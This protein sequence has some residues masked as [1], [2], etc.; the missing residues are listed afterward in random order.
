LQAQGKVIATHLPLH[1]FE[2]YVAGALQVD[3]RRAD[4][5]FKGQVQF[6]DTPAGPQ[7]GVQGDAALDDVRVRMAPVQRAGEGG[8]ADA[9]TVQRR[10]EE[11][12]NWKSLGLRGVD[13][14]LAPGKPVA[15]DVRETALSDF[16]A[17]IIL[18]ANGRINLQDMVRSADASA[19]Q[20]PAPVA[21]GPV[22]AAAAGAAMAP[23][24]Q[25]G[26]VSLTGGRVHFTDYFIQP[27][28]SADLSELTGRIS[29]FSSVPPSAGAA[30]AMAD[31]ELRGR[32]EGTASIEI[33]GK[34]NPLAQPLALDI[35]G[36]MRE[37]ELP[38][39]S[40]YTIKYAGHGI[41]RG[42]L[43]MD[44]NYRV[45]P[46]GQLTA[47][48]KLVLNQLTFGEP[49]DG[50][51]ASL[52]VRL[53]VALL[54]DRNG[55]IDVDLPI[56]GSLNDPEFR[57]GSVILKIIGNLILK[58]VTAPFSLLAGAL[59]GGDELGSVAFAAGS[60]VLDE[61]A[62]QG[63]DKVV[64]ALTDRP[65]LKMTV[66]GMANLE[67]ERD[68]WKRGQLQ[69]NLLAQK[70]RAAL[71]AGQAADEG[72][73]I[74]ADEYPALLKEV[75][76]RSDIAKPRNLVGLAKDLPA[77]EMEALLLASIP[78]S[79]ASMRELALARG[80]AV[81]DYLASRQLPADRL[82]LGAAR[83]VPS[84]A[85]WQPHAELTLGTR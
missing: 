5:S 23:I 46:D 27:N 75:Y 47:S 50:A 58:A 41:E 10:G 54:A 76:R 56:S 11:L 31:L 62:R 71:R 29:A 42:K 2:P 3:I 38:P 43:S 16:F 81:R 1:V 32:A 33:T 35:Q 28:Y 66:V 65:A 22:T 13:V 69:Q 84:E 70:R 79:E 80:V 52:P 61:G 19:A 4:G 60:A 72:Q 45:Q 36:R 8:G 12:L 30:P 49:V 24:I 57:L 78:V 44:V 17:R 64:K 53:A 14:A 25:F 6:A 9:S 37:L 59:G 39:L 34:L 15:V 21:S 67:A 83:V 18:Q 82:F 40:P 20:S 55:V 26:P 48:N 73:T 74:A 7:L 68:A 85:S 77:S 63:L 51:P